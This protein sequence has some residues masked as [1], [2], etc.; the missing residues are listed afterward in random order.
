MSAQSH[1]CTL[2]SAAAFDQRPY[3][4]AHAH[5]SAN[6]HLLRVHMQVGQ[7]VEVL[8]WVTVPPEGEK[9]E[10]KYLHMYEGKVLQLVV[11]PKSCPDVGSKTNSN[12]PMALVQWDT[13]FQTMDSWVPLDLDKYIARE[14]GD[15][16]VRFGWTLLSDKYIHYCQQLRE[17]AAETA[18]EEQ[19]QS[20]RARVA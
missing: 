20:K 12:R 3:T 14:G 18:A 16:K 6:L 5:T 10:Y 2:A 19:Q 11:D 9:D 15:R 4:D 1:W 13:E 7:K 17:E 8:D